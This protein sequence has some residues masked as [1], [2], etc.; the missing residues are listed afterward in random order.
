MTA[1]KNTSARA[2]RAAVQVPSSPWTRSR[3][4]GGEHEEKRNAVL[5]VAADL[6]NHQGYHATSL[7]EIAARLHVTKPTLYYY[8]KSKDDILMGC[9]RKGLDRMLQGIEQT[10]AAGGNSLEQLRA[11]MQVYADIVMQ[12]F[13]MCLIRIGDQ[14]L[15]AA[16]RKKL[17]QVK[18]DIDQAFRGLVIRGVQDGFLAPCDPR[19]TAFAIAGALSWIGRWYRPDG[20]N[21]SE[22]IANQTIDL[23][24]GGLLAAQQEQVA[25]P[26]AASQAARIA[27]ATGKR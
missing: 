13:G 21:T 25:A 9:V 1:K 5:F 12:P 7:D 24:L 22:Q 20:P 2:T 6:F 17:R 3:S 27:G 11:C 23:L 19:I 15:P 14:D 4:R 10:R 26:D 18:S 16:S 8:F